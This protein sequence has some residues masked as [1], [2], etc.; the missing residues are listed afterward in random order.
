VRTCH[1]YVERRPKVL[2]TCQSPMLVVLA[3]LLTIGIVA[4]PT[5]GTVEA[6]H[7]GTHTENVDVANLTIQ[8]G[9]GTANCIVRAADSDDDVFGLRMDYVSMSGFT[10]RN[11]AGPTETRPPNGMNTAEDYVYANMTSPGIFAP[12]DNVSA[13]PV[14]N[15]TGWVV[16]DPSDGYGTILCTTDGGSTWERQGSIGKI[17]N[18][19]SDGV[20]AVDSNTAWVVGGNESCGV[21]LYTTDGGNTWTRQGEG[22][23]PDVELLGVSAVDRNT[24]WAVGYN[25]TVLHTT[26]GGSTWEQQGGG[27]I[28]DVQL[29]G[30]CAV[31]HETAWVTG[32][33]FDGYATIF[34]TTDGGDTWIR[35]GS[36]AEFPDGHFLGVSAADS[37]NAWAVGG[38]TEGTI[39]PSFVFHTT[40]VGNTWVNQAPN[41]TAMGDANEVFAVDVNTAWMV[42]DH[43]NIFCTEN[44]GEDWAKQECNSTFWYLVGVSAIDADTAWVVGAGEGTAGGRILHTTNG[45]D[46]WETQTPPV[47]PNFSKVSFAPLPVHNMDTGES[48]L[49][50][51]GAIDAVNTTDGNTITVDPGNYIENVNVHKQ[52]TIR[53][54]SGNPADTI[55]QAVEADDHVFQVTE[56]YVNITGFTVEGARNVGYAGTYLGSGVEHCSISDND[57]FN[58]G[59]GIYLDSSS[60][61]S[62]T[63]N[64][65]SNNIAAM[66]LGN[67]NNNVVTGNNASENI[68]G[69]G[70]D[71]CSNNTVTN[72]NASNN[73]EGIGLIS[74][75]SN[76]LTGNTASS[77]IFGISLT[78]SGN[79]TLRNNLMSDNSYN[80]GAD[81]SSYSQLDNDVD[82]SNLVDGRPIYYLIGASGTVIDSPSNAGTVFCINCDNVVVKDLTLR[83][84]EYG[85]CFYD[86]TSSRIENNTIS[87]CFGGIQLNVSSNNKITGNK[88]IAGHPNTDAIFL[89]HSDGNT[90]TGNDASQ[91]LRNNIILV[92]SSD[93]SI[94]DNDVT[95]S[96]AGGISILDSSN[97]IITGNDASSSFAHNGINLVESSNNTLTNNMANSNVGHGIY[98][99]SSNNNTL[100]DNI[101]NL[102]SRDGICLESSNDNQ[103]AR[104][105]ILSNLATDSGIHL[106]LDCA[107]NVIH[108][109][110]IVGNS[111]YGVYNENTSEVVD[112]QNNW[113]GAIDGPDDD[114]EI[115]NGSGD[116]ISTNVDANPW[117]EHSSV[118]PAEQTTT[119]TA[120]GTASFSTDG[121]A[122]TDLEA[123]DERTLPT[124]GK[125]DL[126]FSQ[127]FFSF[128]MTG[129]SNGQT[130][131]ITI[132]LPQAVPVG[133]QYWK[134]QND[135]W[136]QIPISGDDGDDVITIALTDG[137]IGDADGEANGV[138]VDPGGPGVPP[139]PTADFSATPTGGAAPLTVQFSDESTGEISSWLWDFG[140]GGTAI[141]Q[142]P[143]HT[144]MYAGRYT[145]ILTVTGP[146]GA[147]T[148]SSTITIMSA[149]EVSPTASFS[150]SY[151]HISPQQVYA[152]NA[153]Q[154]SVSIANNGGQG[155]S[156]QA[157]LIIDGPDGRTT[158]SQTVGV[159]PG[160]CQDVVFT[161]SKTTPGTYDV[162]LAGFEGQ[163]TVTGGEVSGGELGTGGI[164]A[165]VVVAIVFIVA[166]ILTVRSTRREV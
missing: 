97:N 16:G 44:G 90:V 107:G 145:V 55:V 91:N 73:E 146:G 123:V 70:L 130:V 128:N 30:V 54:T 93:N 80:F 89:W 50:I 25:G 122:I 152:N 37:S 69:I 9:N 95:H 15:A 76:T 57:A 75:S 147:K 82:T 129:L 102:N 12:L 103:I 126:E 3:L 72:N 96:M 59:I 131:N 28:P 4:L 138:I 118:T 119:A 21:I 137:G 160:S 7:N 94:T 77:N 52:L 86:T 64:N 116:R 127:G 161:V 33:P 24:A 163:F 36:A 46:T 92:G 155:G 104:N 132:T 114:A 2:K 10:T 84:N 26:D 98:L 135:N 74:S 32:L 124:E 68:A 47:N 140:D 149:A 125:P 71:S 139:A 45:G 110:N 109:N 151:L 112:A 20:S 154:I 148:A 141:D 85:V 158:K 63:G 27:T 38:H 99:E 166:L 1:C 22:E 156:Y 43:G 101:A 60:G 164:V 83:R 8:S 11:A 157:V 40:D 23:I 13:S 79:N 29:Q 39:F 53:S 159:S 105:D 6:S 66:L 115:I 14:H 136:Y 81:G 117:L 108:F 58:N 106:D 144:Y 88:G 87:H 61:N 120:T 142:N 17:P 19:N 51:Q 78:G 41:D 62:I 165:I 56:S 133:T 162:S 48:F 153:V 111:P 67:S 31:D 100:E 113:W 134:C 34:H 143:T 5:A 18:V 49:T 42:Q 150:S 35:Q 121:G 65:A